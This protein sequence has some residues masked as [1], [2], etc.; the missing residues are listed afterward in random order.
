MS[1]H[2]YD[3][4]SFLAEFFPDENDRVEVEEGARRMVALS[5]ATRLTEHA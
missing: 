5:R 2:S 1:T 3:K 4:T